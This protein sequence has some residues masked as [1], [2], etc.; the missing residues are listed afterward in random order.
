MIE[1]TFYR[2]NKYKYGIALFK[3]FAYSSIYK[4]TVWS[5]D[6]V[7]AALVTKMNYHAEHVNKAKNK[8]RAS[9]IDFYLGFKPNYGPEMR[10]KTLEDVAFFKLMNNELLP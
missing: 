5:T 10:F 9:S 1:I 7:S 3:R 6:T 8:L 2:R 4:Y